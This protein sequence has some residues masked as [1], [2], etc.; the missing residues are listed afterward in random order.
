MY[1]LRGGRKT[2]VSHRPQMATCVYH[3]KEHIIEGRL[4]LMDALKSYTHR[5]GH[6]SSSF[7]GTIWYA[8]PSEVYENGF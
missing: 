7:W 2:L 6:Y 1:I 3:K 4:F 8:I 5:L